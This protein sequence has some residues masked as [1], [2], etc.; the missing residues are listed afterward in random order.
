[1]VLHQIKETRGNKLKVYMS[2]IGKCLG[3]IRWS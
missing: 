1:M 3:A 2:S